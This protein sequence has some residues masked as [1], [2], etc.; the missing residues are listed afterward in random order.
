[1][2]AEIET[3][4]FLAAKCKQ[5]ALAHKTVYVLGAWGWPMTKAAQQRCMKEQSFN[6]QRQ[7]K[8]QRLDSGTFGFDCVGLIKGILWGWEG[9]HSEVYGGAGY[10][11]N[12]VPDLNADQMIA[13]C[14][15]VSTDF[16]TIQ[17]GEVVWLPGHIGVYIGNGLA[18]ECT[19]RWTDGVQITAVHNLGKQSG[20]NGRIWEKHGKLPWVTYLTPEVPEIADF[21][22][23]L[24]GLRKGDEGDDVRAL[25][26]LLS[27][28]GCKGNMYASGYGSFGSNTQGAVQLY[29]QKVGLPVTGVAD[30]ST[31]RYLLGRGDAHE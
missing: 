28:N 16:S 27:G 13:Q 22:I 5:I 25:Q 26:I 29:Q 8:L 19:H 20:Y 14:S 30:R 9:N 31:W 21:T 1:M 4:A 18:V 17:A 24:R 7:D 23:P 15:G 6:R 11:C 12:G 10:G 3:A 2:M